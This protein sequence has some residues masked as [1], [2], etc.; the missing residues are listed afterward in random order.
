MHFILD[1]AKKYPPALRLIVTETNV[2]ELKIGNL[3]LIT[4]TGGSVGREG[5]HDVI[6]PDKNVSK[7]RTIE[8]LT[9]QIGDTIYTFRSI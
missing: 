4:Y 8:W 7:V 6:I 5:D 2:P 1:I 3:F 9:I